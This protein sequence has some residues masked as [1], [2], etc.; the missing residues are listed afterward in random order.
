[1]A[2]A[3]STINEELQAVKAELDATRANFRMLLRNT[4]EIA[5]SIEA[6]AII[7]RSDPG[8]ADALVGILVKHAFET[9]EEYERLITS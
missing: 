5:H 1:M 7:L 9:C 6:L 4:N 2:D 3:N 8:P